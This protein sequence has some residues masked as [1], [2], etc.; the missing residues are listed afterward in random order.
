MEGSVRKRGNKWYYSFEAAEIDGKRKRI[1]KVGGNTKAEALSAL[2]EAIKLYENGEVIVE[3]DMSVSDYFD[4]WFNN[5]VEV[6]L[7]Y[8]TRKN[9]RHVINKYIKPEIGKY[10]L[11][12]ITPAKMQE[13]VNKYPDYNGQRLAR[14]TVSIIATVLSGAFRK[15]V[16][17]YQ[18][19]KE[20]P[21]T[22]VEIP[23]YKNG[24]Y[25][26]KVSDVKTITMDQYEKLLEV[27]PPAHYFHMP[28]VLGFHAGLR[29]G[30]VCGLQWQ[31]IS[32]DNKTLSVERIMQIDKNGVRI[33]T[34]KTESSV[35]TIPLD[36]VIID[37]L[38][39]NKKQQLENRMRYGSLFHNSNFV[40]TKDDGGLVTPY[41]IKWC[42][43]ALQ[44]KLGF[45]FHYH[46]LRHTHATMLLEA[47]VSPKIVQDRLGHSKITTTMDTYVHVTKL[48]NDD[49]IEKFEKRISK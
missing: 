29:L 36:S 3:S 42:S 37:E 41:S 17:P 40:C 19:I 47:G 12:A 31:D 10:K 46:M 45:R 44:K 27:I 20:N 6:N 43:E 34:P 9:Y 49:A 13:V 15:A 30:E 4:Y 26:P 18:L 25:K 21:M 33:D 35:R 48:M 28:L 22:Y 14:H 24:G 2:R 16:F 7:K 11:K 38:K 8:N 5:Y 23:N 32:F 1:E 39:R